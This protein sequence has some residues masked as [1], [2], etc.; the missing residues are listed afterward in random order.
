[1]K[2]VERDI[3]RLP[4]PAHVIALLVA[5]TILGAVAS[6]T[7]IRL[8]GHMDSRNGSNEGSKVSRLDGI[9]KIIRRGAGTGRR[10]RVM[11]SGPEVRSSV[12]QICLG[13]IKEG[14]NRIQCSCGR[15]FHIIC[16]SRTASCPY[17]QET[18]ENLIPK[19]S[20]GSSILVC[21]FCETHLEPGSMR[22]RCGAIFREEG[23]D[24]CCPICGTRISEGDLTCQ[25]CGEIF[26]CHRFINCPICGLLVDEDISVCDCGAV[27]SDHCP[28]CGFTL[29]PEERSCRRCG[30]E[31]EFI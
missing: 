23:V 25:Y 1:M 26:D 6:V 19:V 14:S 17:C 24:F 30:A 16:L 13:R 9:T 4:L 31:F 12:C 21:P 28:E 20:G 5:A 18:Y 8:K 27:L 11:I 10:P 2:N 29:G 3:I 15:A 7:A 22:C